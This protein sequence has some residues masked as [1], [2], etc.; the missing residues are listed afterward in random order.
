MGSSEIWDKFQCF[1]HLDPYFISKFTSGIDRSAYTHSD[2]PGSGDFFPSSVT[3][4]LTGAVPVVWSVL[5]SS[6]Q[7][8]LVVGSL[9]GLGDVT[10]GSGGFLCVGDDFGFVGI[11]LLA[12]DWSW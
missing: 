7:A 1:Y 6:V 10:A 3:V 11:S 5:P 9:G 4:T 12:L 2:A 8:G